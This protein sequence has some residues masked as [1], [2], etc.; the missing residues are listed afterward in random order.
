MQYEVVVGFDF[1]GNGPDDLQVL[2]GEV[3]VVE[4]EEGE[5]LVCKTQNGHTGYIPK[6]FVKTKEM[7]VK[8]EPIGSAE[9]LFDFEARNAD[10]ITVTAGQVV[11]ILAK[12]ENEWWVVQHADKSGLVPSNFLKE[13]LPGELE[14]IN[15]GDGDDAG[16][17]GNDNGN[18]F[19]SNPFLTAPRRKSG[20]SDSGNPFGSGPM[21]RNPFGSYEMVDAPINPTEEKNRSEAVVELIQTERAYVEDLQTMVEYFYNPMLEME[22][23]VE[24]LFSNLLEI[25]CVNSTVLEEF[26]K[27]FA[28]GEPIGQVLLN[29]LD[30]LECYKGYCE[31]MAKAS[32]YLQSCR[33]ENP[34]IQE[35]LKVC[36]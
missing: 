34:S 15:A 4:K 8:L 31:N 6:T 2:T 26:E 7:E 5:W 24:L 18:P 3:L 27:S 10:E 14:G 29:H 25:L 13:L 12:P 32:A 20:Q 16:D 1:Q 30:D 22:V 23:N 21:G 11:Q 33:T 28:A 19:A 9:V 36:Y 17:D 35:F